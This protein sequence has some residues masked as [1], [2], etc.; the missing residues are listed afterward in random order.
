MLKKVE[1]FNAVIRYLT[2][3]GFK[4]RSEMEAYLKRNGFGVN[5]LNFYTDSENN[6]IMF[7]VTFDGNQVYMM[8]T[9]ILDGMTLGTMKKLGSIADGFY[10]G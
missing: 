2:R 7:K 1:D 5:Y 3:Y 10:F 4:N 6:N 9:I 8:E